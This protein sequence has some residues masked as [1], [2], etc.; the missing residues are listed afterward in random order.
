MP[1]V[2]FLLPEFD[3]EMSKTRQ[4]L[5]R[6]PTDKLD[7]KPHEKSWRMAELASHIANMV[8]WTTET[9][10]NTSFDV[11]PPGAPPYKPPVAATSEE[12]LAMFDE[13]AKGAREALAGATDAAL[14][15]PWSL[16]MGGKPIFTM[17][18]IAC[19]RGFVMNHAIHHRGQL[20]VYLRLAGIPV[21]GMYGPSGDD[22][23]TFGG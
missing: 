3:Q 4:M 14:M 23:N 12:L 6:I 1:I 10:K 20:S 5:E 11:Q 13:S 8:G 22:P 9:M 18:R 15:Q 19:I 17:P 16:L 21:P 2:D 7:F